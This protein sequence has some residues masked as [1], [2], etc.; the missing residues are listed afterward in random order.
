MYYVPRATCCSWKLS[1]DKELWVLRVVF[2]SS[3]LKTRNKESV[4]DQAEKVKT[5]HWQKPPICD[6]NEAVATQGGLWNLTAWVQILALPSTNHLTLRAFLHLP[7]LRG[8]H[9]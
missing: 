8:P 9:L 4:Q 1:R 3:K 6:L 2:R 7:E 5:E